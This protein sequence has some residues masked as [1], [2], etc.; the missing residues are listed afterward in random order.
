[1]TLICRVIPILFQ[2][3]SQI[4]INKLVNNP[5]AKY[6]VIRLAVKLYYQN[7]RLPANLRF[8]ICKEPFIM[9]PMIMFTQKNSVFMEEINQKLELFISA[10]LTELWIKKFLNSKAKEFGNHQTA[11]SV[12]IM[13]GCFVLLMM[14]ISASFIAFLVEKLCGKF[15]KC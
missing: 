6:A 9:A 12:E 4:F 11:L 10:G 13:E 14:G 15:I 8:V 2:S 7:Q 5:T 3:D 1:M